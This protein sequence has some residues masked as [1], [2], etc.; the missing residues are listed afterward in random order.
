SDWKWARIAPHVDLAGEHV[1]DVGAGNGFFGWAMLDAGAES[2]IGCDP[3]Q[4]FIH[5]HAAIC[6]FAGPAPNLLLAST[7][8]DLDPA[9]SGF[10]TVCSFGVLYHRRDHLDHLYRL[11]ERLK[12]AGRLVLE[13]LILPGDED[14]QLDAPPRYANMRNVHALPTRARL[15]KWMEQAGYQDCHCVDVTATTLEEQ[16]STDWMPFHSLK[17]ALDPQ[18]SR[19]TIEGL[20]APLRAVIIARRGT[21]GL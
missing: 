2:V 20:P 9:L 21:A 3:T 18:D 7:L 5:Q 14:A 4:L 15:L 17:E 16:R 10:D 8:E 11:A 13:T 12:P 6:H 1:L 19:Q